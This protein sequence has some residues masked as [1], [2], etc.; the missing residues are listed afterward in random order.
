MLVGCVTSNRAD[1]SPLTTRWK[2]PHFDIMFVS[3][4]RDHTGRSF[5]YYE[6]K[7]TQAEAKLV[8]GSGHCLDGLNSTKNR[9][10]K[11]WTRIIEDPNGKALLIEE[12]SPPNDSGLFS[13]YLWVHMESPG[14]LAGTYVRLPPR[15]NGNE[16][17][18]DYEYPRVLSLNG[19]MLT[20]SYVRGT[21]IKKSI[22]SIEKAD[23]PLPPG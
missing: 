22:K 16:G 18:V 21:A 15:S 19:E 11:N 17:G 20:F 10:P 6:I 3:G 2:M 13:N 9:D 7:H 1:T 8:I 5:S 12:V 23:E 14:Y 4:S